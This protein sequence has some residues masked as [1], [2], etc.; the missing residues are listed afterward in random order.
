[1]RGERGRREREGKREVRGKVTTG[2]GGHIKKM[3]VRMNCDFLEEVE[4]FKE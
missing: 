2:R 1:M 3:N 4:C